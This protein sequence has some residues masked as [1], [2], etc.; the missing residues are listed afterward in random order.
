MSIVLAVVL[1]YLGLVLVVGLMGHR[2]FRGTGEDYFLAS[3]TIGPFVLLMT[4][5]GTNMT[6]FTMLGASGESH[7]VGISVFMLMATSSSVIIPFA[8]LLVGTRLWWLGKRHGFMTQAQFLRARYESGAVGLVMFIVVLLFL[9]PYVLIGVKGGGDVLTAL[10]GGPGVGLRPWVG[11]VLMC[12]VIFTYVTYGGMRSTAWANTLQTIVFMSVGAL[13]FFVILGEYGGMDAA[14]RTVGETKA[15]LL[16]VGKNRNQLAHMVSYMLLP[17]SVGAFPH[18]FSHW[19]SARSAETFRSSIV[20]YPVCVTLVW[21]PSVV[22]GVVGN[23][24]F[25]PPVQGPILVSLILEHAGGMLAGLLAAG[26][27][28]AIMSSLDSQT[29]AAG[30]MFTTDIVR[31]YGFHDRLTERQQVLF[32][33]LFVMGFLATVLGL[34]FVTSRSI[35]SLGVWSLSGFAALFP[36][37]F[38][39]LYWRRSTGTGAVASIL[40]VAALWGVFFTRSLGTQGEYTIAGSGVLPVVVMFGAACGSLVIVSLLTS[41]PSEDVVSAFVPRPELE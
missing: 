9:L 11:S 33:R 4:L 8:F 1:V 40:T 30:T 22:L 23:I 14:M 6:A 2:L 12:G 36:V 31:H 19:L 32:G 35:F 15:S 24:D 21:V 13:A 16:S 3:R 29:L 18:I 39:A 38:A 26:V 7:R 34:S 5:F 17:L 37:M 10:T 28:A 20:L 25:P 27:F 41:P